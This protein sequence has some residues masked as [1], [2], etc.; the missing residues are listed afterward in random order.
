MTKEGEGGEG[1]KAKRL[2]KREA[3]KIPTNQIW[4]KTEE[5]MA[6]FPM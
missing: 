4:G 2:Q 3:K 5:A 1:L 6:S